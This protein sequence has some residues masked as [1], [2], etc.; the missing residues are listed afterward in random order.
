[1]RLTKVARVMRITRVYLAVVGSSILYWTVLSCTGLF[2]A[3]VD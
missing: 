1:M 3:V 2:Y